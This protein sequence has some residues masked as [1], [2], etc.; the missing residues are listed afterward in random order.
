MVTVIVAS[1]IVQELVKTGDVAE[2]EKINY[3][4]KLFDLIIQLPNS[5]LL[6][7]A[8]DDAKYE[9]FVHD[10]SLGKDGTL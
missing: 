10:A 6:K 1:E 9:S 8:I 3:Q 7:S 5:H 2:N 4:D